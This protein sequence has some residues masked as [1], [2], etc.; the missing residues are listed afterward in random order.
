MVLA[1]LGTRIPSQVLLRAFEQR[2]A[3]GI[4]K[5][6]LVRRF[7]SFWIQVFASNGPAQLGGRGGLGSALV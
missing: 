4:G 7:V 2:E 6:Q 1:W 3:I 5:L